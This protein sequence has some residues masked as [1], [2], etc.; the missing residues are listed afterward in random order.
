MPN[1]ARIAHQG[2]M[3]RL[4]PDLEPRLYGPQRIA[5][6][7]DTLAEDGIAPALA[8]AGSDITEAALKDVST[9][10]S[11]RQVMTVFRNAAQLAADPTTA[12]R[13][14]QRMH[15][16]AYGMYG[17]GLLSSPTFADQ[18]EFAIKYNRVMGPVA[19]PIAFASEGDAAVYTYEVLLTPDPNDELFRFALD[20]AF[21]AH[22]TMGRDLY[23]SPF[24]FRSLHASFPAPAHA[25]RYP[26][27]FGCPVQFGCP[28]D[29]VVL[30]AAWSKVPTQ[31]PDRITHGSVRDIC[32]QFLVDLTHSGATASAVR[33]TLVEQMPWR[34]PTIE[35]MAEA[36]A[37][38]PRT[39]RRRLESEGTSFKDL[40][41]EVRRRL[42]IE[43]LRRTKM[44]TEEIATRLGYSD[45]ANF[46]H[47][48]ARWTGKTPHV[49]RVG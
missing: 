2:T 10:V 34:F 43:Y 11:Y 25:D 22:L 45:A 47:A 28:H 26:A 39:L 14:G 32:Q 36:L 41:S 27:M 4:P 24:A 37:L 6:M 19:G 9:R 5:A 29:E 20:F 12:F 46:R 23:G 21:S 13:A 35:S 15:L 31:M 1:G 17:Y 42:A 16:T 8:L 40:L 3:H 48:F 30:D 38:H 7:I 33:R 44:T 49:Y 18:V